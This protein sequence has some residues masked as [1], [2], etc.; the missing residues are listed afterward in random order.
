MLHLPRRQ[1]AAGG[2]SAADAS[3]LSPMKLR[4]TLTPRQRLKASQAHVY[5]ASQSPTAL[6]CGDLVD[7]EW[8]ATWFPGVI[9]DIPAAGTLAESGGSAAAFAQRF[10]YAAT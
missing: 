1:S 3:D 2:A 7:V 9:T 4:A 6:R 5:K 10:A 8:E